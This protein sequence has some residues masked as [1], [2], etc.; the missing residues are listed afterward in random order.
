MAVRSLQRKKRITPFSISGEQLESGDIRLLSLVIAEIQGLVTNLSIG[1]GVSSRQAG[2]FKGQVIDHIFV[3]AN[4]LNTIPHGLGVIPTA[5]IPIL[6]DR[7]CD[8]YDTNFR[9]GWGANQIQL[10]SS[11]ASA[12]VKLLLLA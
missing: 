7:A 6:K 1:D 8:L 10:F 9:A 12:K 3:S 2:N 11:V 5:V 4:V